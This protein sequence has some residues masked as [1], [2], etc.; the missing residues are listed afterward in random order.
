MSSS[1]RLRCEAWPANFPIPHEVELELQR[2]HKKLNDET[3]LNVESK[4]KVKSEILMSL[5]AEIIKYKAYPK[6]EEY[7]E[8]VKALI[9][10]HPCL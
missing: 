9:T 8:V 6:G 3:S 7:E 10:K 1:S 2:A 5:A 4:P